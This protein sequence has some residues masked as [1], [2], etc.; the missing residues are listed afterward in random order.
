[1]CNKSLSLQKKKKK[2]KIYIYECLNVGPAAYYLYFSQ[3][4]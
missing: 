2:D 3:A 1:M 4:C